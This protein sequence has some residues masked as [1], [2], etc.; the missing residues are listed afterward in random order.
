MT[1]PAPTT[2]SDHRSTDLPGARPTVG[3]TLLQTAQTFGIDLPVRYVAWEDAEGV[4]HVAHPDIR[5]L[6][7]RHGATGVDDTLDMVETATGAFSDAAAGE[8]R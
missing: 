1:L 2:S 7:T 5:V 6:A 3:T 4:V 8:L